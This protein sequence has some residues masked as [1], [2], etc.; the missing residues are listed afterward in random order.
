[1]SNS[2]LRVARNLLIVN[3][4]FSDLM[5]CIFCMP[6]TLI[7]LLSRTWVMGSV[8]CRCV[9]FVQGVTIF[10]SSAT[11]S[12]IAI[13]RQQVI[14]NFNGNRKRVNKGNCRHMLVY[15]TILWAFSVVMAM[16]ILFSKSVTTVSLAS[17]HLYDKCIERWPSN[18][19]RAS[20]TVLI[21]C[22]QFVV[23]SIVLTVTHLR[24][25]AYLNRSARKHDATNSPR[26]S[27]RLKKEL[28]R[29]R[30][31]TIV[32]CFISIAFACSWLPWNAFNLMAD[33]AFLSSLPPNDFY[34]AF[35]ICHLVAMSSSVTNPILYGWF[36]SNVRREIRRVRIATIQNVFCK[37]GN[38]KPLK[39]ERSNGSALCENTYIR[40]S[41]RRDIL[42]SQL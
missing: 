16:P 4:S 27:E 36:N 17:M 38:A 40:S 19:V 18:C 14:I 25:K 34:M 15:T 21:L 30:K 7:E 24:I 32:L 20:Y 39:P 33:F 5:L 10:L 35:V 8:L 12:A 3:L 42:E 9:P 29:N 22:A 1:M 28:Y 13:D 37:M 41:A 2:R 6:F 11:V 23:P 31:A 26:T